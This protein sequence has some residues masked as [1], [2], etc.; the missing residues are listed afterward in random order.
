MDAQD[1]FD[2]LFF[3]GALVAFIILLLMGFAHWHI[4]EE[5]RHLERLQSDRLEARHVRL[6]MLLQA[7]RAG[8]P[9]R[10]C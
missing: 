3:L 5:R 7:R 4:Q 9:R 10:G 2:V 8:R 1:F 6:A